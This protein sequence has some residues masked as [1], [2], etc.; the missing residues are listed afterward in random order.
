MKTKQLFAAI[1]KTA[2][3]RDTQ[4]FVGEEH[5][6]APESDLWEDV[7]NPQQFI[8]IYYGE[9]ETVLHDAAAVA[10]CC[11]D[12]VRLLPIAEMIAPVDSQAD[13]LHSTF[14]AMLGCDAEAR[15]SLLSQACF[16]D[17]LMKGYAV[18]EKKAMAASE[19]LAKIDQPTTMEERRYAAEDLISTFGFP[20]FESLSDQELSDLLF[21]RAYTAFMDGVAEPMRARREV[22]HAGAAEDTCIEEQECSCCQKHFLLRYHGRWNGES[23]VSA[24]YDYV[25]D[26]CDCEAPFS[27][28]DGNSIAG[29]VAAH[30]N[31][32]GAEG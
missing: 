9:K 12:A 15:T 5:E 7:K 28:V 4:V 18:E 27:P 32:E 2:F 14:W 11:E 13:I 6:I 19:R 21:E 24:G 20:A 17:F 22:I 23:F 29:W 30:N 26:A 8:G 10:G 25:G 31:K 1:Y 16:A 3:T